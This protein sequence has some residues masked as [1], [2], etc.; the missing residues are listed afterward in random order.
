M[1]TEH[2]NSNVYDI[3]AADPKLSKDF[4]SFVARTLKVFPMHG[5]YDFTF[6]QK[7][8][9]TTSTESRPL[10]VGI[11]GS[12]GHAVRDILHDHP[13]LPHERCAVFDRAPRIKHIRT[14]LDEGIELICSQGTR[15][16]RSRH[17]CR[18][19]WSINSAAS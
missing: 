17:K 5:V 9:D 16:R 4:E 10:L 15:L 6:M 2:L 13:W 8:A 11:G 19:L 3:V 18:P 7:Q 14:E 1:A 12:K